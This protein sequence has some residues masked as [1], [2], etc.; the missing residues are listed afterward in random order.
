[1]NND[2]SVGDEAELLPFQ[3]AQTAGE[4]RSAYEENNREG[5]LRDDQRFLERGRFFRVAATGAT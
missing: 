4:Q 1:M 2:T 3:M 5:N